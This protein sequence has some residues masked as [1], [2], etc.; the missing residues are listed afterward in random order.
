M[1]C[2]GAKNYAPWSIQL[3]KQL[4]HAVH[5]IYIPSFLTWEN[6][7]SI[8][9]WGDI[10]RI[11]H[12]LQLLGRAPLCFNIFHLGC[13]HTLPEQGNIGGNQPGKSPAGYWFACSQRKVWAWKESPDVLR[14][15][16]F[17]EVGFLLVCRSEISS[18]K[19]HLE[20]LIF[21]VNIIPSQNKF[22]SVRLS[23]CKDI[24]QE[25]IHR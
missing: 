2:G 10:N 19:R 14:V 4:L 20:N 6:W 8:E 7:K 11:F 21:L 13:Q 1:N 3:N 23:S 22:C 17:G 9:K 15:T 12:S 5:I 16:F 18:A 24:P 25:G